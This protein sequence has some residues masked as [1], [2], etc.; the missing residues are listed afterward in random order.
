MRASNF[1]PDASVVRTLL[2]NLG[3]VDVSQTLPAVPGYLFLGVHALDLD[4][5]RVFLLVRL[6]SKTK[7]TRIR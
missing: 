6:R 7:T 3:L 5:R 4:Q 2:L 1:T